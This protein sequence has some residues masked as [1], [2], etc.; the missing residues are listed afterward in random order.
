MTA[1]FT[2]TT[3]TPDLATGDAHI[4]DQHK[5][6]IDYLNQLFD[7]HKSDKG[8]KEVKRTMVFLVDYTVKHF[9]DE[10]AFLAKHNYPDL[11]RHKQIHADF[12]ATAKKL[13]EDLAQDISDGGPSDE[14]ITNVYGIV[15]K[16]V[17]NHIKGEDLKW[18][19]YLRNK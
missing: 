13:L 8:S 14:F 10:Q 17:I 3:W 12:T 6:L 19:E 18:A 1:S 5:Q 4:D 2:Y 16:W 9:G 11:P 7:A 15:G